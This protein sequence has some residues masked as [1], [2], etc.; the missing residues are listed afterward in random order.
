MG[1]A[2]AVAGELSYAAVTE[3]AD[4]STVAVL[5]KSSKKKKRGKKSLSEGLW[6]MLLSYSGLMPRG[7]VNR[8]SR[9][10][11]WLRLYMEYGCRHYHAKLMALTREMP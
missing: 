9:N 5:A 3:I 2:G 6:L 1:S 4:G 10:Y 7:N 11:C 8:K